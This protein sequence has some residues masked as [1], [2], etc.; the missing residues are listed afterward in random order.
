[1]DKLRIAVET[2][3]V[4]AAKDILQQ[5]ENIDLNQRIGHDYTRHHYTTLLILACEKECISMVKLLALNRKYPADVDMPDSEGRYPISV[6]VQK[7][8]MK[9][10]AL[11]LMEATAN[12]NI[13]CGEKHHTTTP[14]IMACE[15]WVNM[16]IVKLLIENKADVNMADLCGRTPVWQAV[17]TRN[18]PLARY[19]LRNTQANPDIHVKLLRTFGGQQIMT[20]PLTEACKMENNLDMVE[21]LLEHKVT[22]DV[23]MADGNGVR[24]LSVALKSG[25]IEIVHALLHAGNSMP[26]DTLFCRPISDFDE[27]WQA[28]GSTE[29]TNPHQVSAHFNHF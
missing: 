17:V 16:G 6:A 8:S 29:E 28:W 5:N 1:M 23:N 18:F 10:V 3:D 25:N 7:R 9:L 27:I 24:P 14:L 2:N 19:L 20:T 22:H 15:P 11:L 13:C 4:K 26:T 12:P 21:L